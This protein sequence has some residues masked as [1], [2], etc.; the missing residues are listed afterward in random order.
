MSTT[1]DEKVVSLR[2]D[3][4]QFEKNISTTMST[5]DKFKQKL[6]FDGASKGLNNVQAAANT[7]NTNG[8]TGLSAGVEAVRLKFSAMQVM[9]VTA[10]TNLTNSAMNT[11]KRM[12]KALTIDPI[13]TGFQEYETQ[14]NAVQTILA[15]TKSK[16]STI[17]DVNEALEELNA[18]ADKTIYNFTEMTR[19]IGTFTAAGIELD[20]ATNAIQ[21]IANL[22][23]VSG[24]TSQQASTAMYQ[25]SQALAA[26]SVKLQD[27][28]SVV[29]A[30]MGGEMFQNALRETS[31]LLG[32]GAEAAIA[33]SG[34]F[35]ESLKQGWITSEV[36]TE[37]LKKFTTS[38]ANEYIAEYTGMTLEAVEAETERIASAEDASKA[39]DEVAESL[40][41]ASGKSKEEIKQALDFAQTAEDAATKV[42]T[43]TQLWDVLKES[44]QSGWS[45]TWKLL[46]GDFEQAKAL[47]TP[48]ADFLTGAIGKMSDARNTLLE[49]A[50]GKSFTGLADK[51]KGVVAP[52]TK[53]AEAIGAVVDTIKDYSVITD[54]IM[55]GKWGNGQERW[56]ALAK[57]GYDW[58]HAQNLVNERL[59][60][61]K[62]HATN[63]AEAQNG[64]AEAQ[65]ASTQSQENYILSLIGK[66]DAELKELK[67]NEEQIAA[68]RELERQSEKTGIP[69]KEFIQNLD[70]IDGR[71]LLINSLKNVGKSLV[72]VFTAIGEAW[73]DAFPPMQADTLYNLIAGMHK[74]ST[75]LVIGEDTAGE[76][77]RALKGL[78]ALVDIGVGVVTG[79]TNGA[80][81]IGVKIIQ[82][83]A[84]A[85]GYT[86][87][88][89]L[90]IAANV[91]DAIV[92]FRDWLEEHNLI[93]KAIEKIVPLVVDFAIAVGEMIDKLYNLPSVQAGINNLAGR[94]D[95]F[96][97]TV[98][99]TIKGVIGYLGSIDDFSLDKLAQGISVISESIQSYLESIG[100]DF[101]SFPG[102]LIE[103]F[104]NGII[105]GIPNAIA[106]MIE[107][108]KRILAAFGLE[109]GCQSPSW[110]TEQ[111]GEYTAEGFVV[112]IQNGTAAVLN[113]IVSFAEKI[114]GVLK[115]VDWSQVFAG[116]LAAG[117][118]GSIYRIAKAF[119]AIASPLQGLG[120]MFDGVGTVLEK[121]AKSISKVIKS[122]AKVVKGFGKVLTG[123]SWE[124]K[125]KAMK[126][127]AIA[128]A[129]LAGSIWL[130][131]KIEN[132]W[133]A[134]GVIVALSATLLALG[135]AA[136]KFG[137]SGVMLS[138]AGLKI[139][140][141][142]TAFLTIGASLL[143]LAAT[144][145]L[146]GGMDPAAIEQGFKALYA[147]V[148]AMALVFAAYG[149]LVKGDAAQNI[150]KA[151]KLMRSMSITLL[152]MVGVIKL[153]ATISEDELNAGMTVVTAF[154]AFVG[155]MVGLS[156]VAG[157]NIDKMGSTIL[158]ISAA[159]LLMIGVA[160]LAGTLDENEL[161]KGGIA[162]LAMVAFVG[163]LVA[164]TT[165]ANDKQIAKVGM[166]LLSVS[167]S[168]LIMVGICK[169]I[170]TMDFNEF[171]AGSAGIAVF[172]IMIAALIKVV[173][174]CGDAP[175]IAAT[176]LAM[177]AAIAI[178]AGVAILLNFVP[179]EGLA[180]GVIAIGLL[181]AVMTGMIKATKGAQNVKGA[182]M[183]MAVAIGVMAAALIALSFIDPGKLAS[184]TAALSTVMGIF[185]LVEKMAGKIKAK[186]MGALIVITVAVTL[187]GGILYA[188][189]T[190]PWQNALAGAVALSGVMLAFS[191]AL[192]IISKADNVAKSALIAVG[193][194]AAV[195][196]VLGGIIYLL[197]KLPV[198]NVLGAAGSLSAL[199]LTLSA[200]VLILSKAGPVS[201]AALIAIAK[202]SAVI[203]AIAAVLGLIG[204][205]MALIPEDKIEAAKTGLANLMDFLVIFTTGIGEAIGGFV[206]GVMSCLPG[207]AESLSSFI[208]TMVECFTVQ[209]VKFDAKVLEGVGYLA[210]AIILMS[211]AS[212]IAGITSILTLGTGF[213]NMGAQLSLFMFT[214]KPFFENISLVNPAALQGVKALAEAILTLTAANVIE[215]LTAW[216]TGGSSLANFGSQLGDLGSNMSTFVTNLGTFTPA[217]VTTVECAAN[218]IKIL[219]AAANEI[220]NDS[221]WA[222]KIFGENSLASFGAYF[223]Q[224]GTDLA[225]LVTNLGTFTEAQVTTVK[226]AG[227]AITTLAE[228]ANSI[229][230]DGGFWARI[231]GENS[232]S[233]FSNKLPGLG[234]HLATFL[235]NLG[236]FGEDQVNAAKFAGQAITSLAEAAN[237]IPNE[238]GVFEKIFG[239]N[240]LSTFAMKLPALGL[241]LSSFIRNLG[242]FTEE[243]VTTVRCAGQAITAFAEAANQI[244]AEGGV[245]EKI[246]GESGLA[247]FSAQLPAL[248]SNMSAFITNLGVFSSEQITAVYAARNAISA[249]TSLAEID[250]E[251]AG[252]SLVNF[253]SYLSIFASDF[254][255]F[256]NT[257]KAAGSANI[258]V[259]IKRTQEV[260]DMAKTVAEVNISSLKTFGSSLVKVAKDGINDFV[261]AFESEDP[262]RDIV[263]AIENMIEAAMKAVEDKQPDFVL[264]FE[265]LVNAAAGA[266]DSQT[267]YDDFYASG[268]WF[269]EGLVAGIEA[270]WDEVYEAAYELGQAAVQ[271]ERDGQESASPSKAM[272][273]SGRWLGEGLIIGVGKMGK[274]VYSAGSKLGGMAT[275][276]ISGA[277]STVFDLLG[278]EELGQPTIRPVMDLTEIQNGIG[279]M[280]GMF[281]NNPALGVSA[282]LNAISASMANRNQNGLNSDVVAAINKLRG[283]LSNVSGNSYTIQGIT[284]DDG[285]NMAELVQA[286]IRAAQVERRI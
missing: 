154:T 144:V 196:A 119:E 142:K 74:F 85:L 150:D 280:N 108:G 54:E 269:G 156:M 201:D 10:L 220:P 28:N 110:K 47:L 161:T 262:K 173:D 209:A 204:G 157:N 126:E 98:G 21:G 92:A 229:P 7:L 231:F 38:G 251:G 151:G 266:L 133:E 124:M 254:A 79:L 89:L 66:T 44:A 48:L 218:A 230:N 195:T 249:I 78:F 40:A 68:L 122:T 35:R 23:A 141:L 117:M 214:A 279:S 59:G 233:T 109:I 2:F 232:L 177:S 30:G 247:A 162:M 131:S 208:N 203:V 271:G 246:F 253:G 105:N 96:Y 181:G 75:Y 5:L 159:M 77:T 87:V 139:D 33:A 52:V 219:A 276:S 147:A 71:F 46:V 211:G 277:L 106:A 210:A 165:I 56:D 221:G 128:I 39:I 69:I 36:L 275:D 259:A 178:L 194:M 278:S 239:E 94:F 134:V 104:S 148:G 62:R 284:Y 164:V 83:F 261:D 16:G 12:M 107:F 34:S 22:A 169:L 145:K 11:G 197:A 57:A 258:M 60:S 245:F 91:G 238:G 242:T 127:M 244:P 163:A 120:S 9:G 64:V 49:S 81:K 113:A 152:L 167:T 118:I 88:N 228:A 8:M 80:F 136:E 3:N 241:Y 132:P 102:D 146:L 67:L 166:M 264:T 73:R 285:S 90:S 171:V 188:L 216:F 155:V 103:G 182:I 130:L 140:G 224:L 123:I 199:L 236:T 273:K 61:A 192:L 248:G 223:G 121:S 58:A 125:A 270:M 14:I 267:F 227:Q 185:A 225:A 135:I 99:R 243:Q 272:I 268:E 37:T 111:I 24:S 206:D 70:Q 138:K 116:G 198:E 76:L 153:A 235:R 191:A 93:Y 250:L 82:E 215:G 32:T 97:N 160:K 186:S 212:L 95:Y 234:M 226:C 149:L 170:A 257:I 286:L 263:R 86:D 265:T 174:G 26:G 205:L 200:S 172:G 283:D 179:I 51:I 112:G 25:L 213:A 20:T 72:T 176:L 114:I 27:W 143:L 190:Q 43:F 240:S 255:S 193:V 29:N 42:K 1:I 13:K 19:N 217:Q 41:N 129:I 252:Y 237:S 137:S 202:I 45:Q 168:M 15:N 65:E 18:Y 207:V 282:N 101:E 17:D 84:K 256:S 187:L 6:K 55:G 115:S 184:A 63:Y 222:G 175:K 183:A 100:M 189:S 260:I 274:K 31:E 50:L 53:S 281:N 4:K 158:K 180:K